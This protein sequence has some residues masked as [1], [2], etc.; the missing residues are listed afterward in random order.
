MSRLFIAVFSLA[1]V[2]S[3]AVSAQNFT[4]LRISTP[5]PGSS[6]SLP[7]ALAAKLELDKA[8]GT[9]LRIKYVGGGGF[10]QKDLASGDADFGL[11][12]IT[13]AMEAHLTDPQFVAIAATENQ[14][15]WLLMV[16]AQLRSE[17]GSLSALS[18]RTI[19][20]HSNSRIFKSASQQVIEVLL[21]SSKIDL[22]AVR[23]VPVGQNWDSEVA[24]FSS[25]VDAEVVDEP[26][27]TRMELQG[28]AAP[29]VNTLDLASTAGLTEFRFLRGAII[30][31]RDK[32][33]SKPETAEKLIQI[34]RKSL[35]WIAAHSPAEIA[36][37]LEI[38][39][40]E[41]RAFLE[42]HK[43]YPDQYSKDAKFSVEQMRATQEFFLK[44]NWENRAGPENLNKGLSGF[45]A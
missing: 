42:S 39:G 40:D 43:R 14:T 8:A 17:I 5:G 18:G 36:A 1:M 21:R 30:S 12:G 19:G 45:S 16:K 20:I 28:L 27:G 3:I 22:G 32:I 35:E 9:I 38:T 26:F 34:L 10:A 11:F 31:R 29:L 4:E 15:P 33:L 13:A 2:V 6:V 24:G 44:A 25:Q 23:F 37:K 41:A 7:I